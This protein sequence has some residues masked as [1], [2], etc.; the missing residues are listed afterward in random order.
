MAAAFVKAVFAKNLPRTL[1]GRFCFKWGE[2]T[3]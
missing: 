3:L 1:R 2:G